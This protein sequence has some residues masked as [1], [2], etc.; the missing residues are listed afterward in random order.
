[1]ISLKFAE[2][3]ENK[4]RSEKT[5]NGYLHDLSLFARWFKGTNGEELAPHLLTPTDVREY[6]A[7]LQYTHKAKP[8]TINR[9]LAA[10]RA[11]TRWAKDSGLIDYYPLNGIKGVAEQKMGAKWLDR[12]QELAVMRELERRIQVASTGPVRF[13]AVRNKAIIVLFINTGLRLGELQ[14]LELEDVEIS[15]RKGEV[16]V[17]FGKGMKARD[18]PLNNTARKV[19]QEWYDIRPQTSDRQLFINRKGGSLSSRQISNVATQTGKA[20]DVELSPHMLRHTFGKSLVDGG[21]TLEKVAMLMGHSS[22]D[23]TKVYI[24]PSMNDLEQAVSVR[25]D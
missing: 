23:T 13:L 19:L 15:D 5:V 20:A 21:V 1:M 7:Y 25:D 8:S 9:H 18:I 6:R 4:D 22:L 3:L 11:Y 17:R 14:A 16:R 10:I 2:Y 24:T 12:K